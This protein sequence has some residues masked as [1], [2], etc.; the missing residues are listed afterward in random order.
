MFKKC[1]QYKIL[2]WQSF[3]Q[4][5]V[6]IRSEL[7]E[8]AESIRANGVLQPILVRPLTSKVHHMK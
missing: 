1:F 7:D 6:L 2:F 4:E 5:K 3:N 8:L